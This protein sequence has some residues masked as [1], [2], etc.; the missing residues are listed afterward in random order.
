MFSGI[1]IDYDFFLRQTDSNKHDIYVTSDDEVDKLALRYSNR[2]TF[3]F[4]SF[5]S[6]T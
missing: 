2:M 6:N 4:I 3:L 1:M 5:I